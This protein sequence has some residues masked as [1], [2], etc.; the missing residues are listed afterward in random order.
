MERRLTTILAADVVGYSRLTGVNEAG[1]IDALKTLR[2]D[3]VAPKI[4]E[5]HGRIVKLTGDGI[6]V[7]FPREVSAVACAASSQR[8]VRGGNARAPHATRI[9]FRTG[10]HR[11]DA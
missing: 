6:L 11:G 5:H 7:E 8:A 9:D 4:A 1:T 3:L 10:V 2:K